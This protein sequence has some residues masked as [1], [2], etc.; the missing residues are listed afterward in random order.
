MVQQLLHGMATTV[1]DCL[2]A[3]ST[4]RMSTS[5]PRDQAHFL[6]SV[7]NMAPLIPPS[8]AFLPAKGK[9]QC[10]LRIHA[11]WMQWTGSTASPLVGTRHHRG[12]FKG[13]VR[14]VQGRAGCTL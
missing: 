6:L 2:A 1:N 11:I 9:L 3:R 14:C 12:L 7:Q 8:L 5:I 10:R 13:V 4:A